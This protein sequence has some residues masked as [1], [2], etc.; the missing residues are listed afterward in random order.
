MTPDRPTFFPA[1]FDSACGECTGEMFQGETIAAYQG[2]YMHKSCYE[3]NHE[4]RDEE[5]EL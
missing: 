3:D 5:F 4:T 2:D 1:S